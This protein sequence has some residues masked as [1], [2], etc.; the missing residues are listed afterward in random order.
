MPFKLS[1][2]HIAFDLVFCHMVCL[3]D[4]QAIYFLSVFEYLMATSLIKSFFSRYLGFVE[5][6]SELLQEKIGDGLMLAL[7]PLP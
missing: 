1:S 5:L 7:L 2:L 6:H 4:L 3:L